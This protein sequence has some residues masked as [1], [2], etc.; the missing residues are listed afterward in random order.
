MA[1]NRLDLLDF[2]IWAIL[3]PCVKERPRKSL[4][5]HRIWEKVI[6]C[7]FSCNIPFFVL[8]ATC[9]EV[10]GASEPGQQLVRT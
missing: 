3:C 7:Q 9:K 4:L 2:M 8:L 1:S 10:H 6:G 5:M